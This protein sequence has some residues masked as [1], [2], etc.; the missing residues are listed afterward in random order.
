MTGQTSQRIFQVL[1][2]SQHVIYL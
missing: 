2:R 1:S